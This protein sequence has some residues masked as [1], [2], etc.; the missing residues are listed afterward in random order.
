MLLFSLLCLS[1]ATAPRELADAFSY[2]AST[3]YDEAAA[4]GDGNGGASAQ[5][6]AMLKISATGCAGE[7]V[8]W[9]RWSEQQ[10]F[11]SVPGRSHT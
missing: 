3:S 1:A 9:C 10:S 8:G 6:D 4:A 11:K 7:D 2:S 5:D